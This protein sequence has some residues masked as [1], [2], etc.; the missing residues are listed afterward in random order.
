MYRERDKPR[1]CRYGCKHDPRAD[2]GL[3]G[4]AVDPDSYDYAGCVEWNY[5]LGRLWDAT[6]SRLS[7][8]FKGATY[9]K[10]GEFQARG[11]LHVHVLVRMRRTIEPSARIAEAMFEACRSVETRDGLAWG[12]SAGDCQHVPV[13]E[14]QDK[15]AFYMTKVLAYVTK[16]AMVL[17]GDIDVRAADH[18]RRLD[19]AA[20][21]M[22]CDRCKSWSEPCNG[23]A[24]RRWGARS[25]VLSKSRGSE[26][27]EGWS[28]LRRLDL[29]ER[30]AKFAQLAAKKNI[31]LEVLA[32]IVAEESAV[33]RSSVVMMT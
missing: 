32:R 31:A 17:G 10:V 18:F 13:G 20:R 16:D 12:R 8:E 27:R 7:K 22:R 5:G 1:K 11:A 23:L 30:R 33:L 25:S 9:A 19:S 29:R 28:A 24:H 21:H 26:K 14:T 2:S 6:R 3:R 15:V 4:V